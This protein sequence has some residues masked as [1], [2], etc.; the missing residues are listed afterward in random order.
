MPELSDSLPDVTLSILVPVF[1]E[2]ATLQRALDR[3]L[4]IDYGGD[5]E[6]VA[7]DDGSSDGSAEILARQCDSRLKVVTHP[8]N[9]GKGAA[10]RTG[11][12]HATGDVMSVCDAD[13]EYNPGDL[14]RLYAV[15]RSGEADVVFGTR[16]FGSHSAYSFWYVMG[17]RV[18]TLAANVLFDCYLSDLETCFKM[19]PRELFLS[20]GIASSGFGLE[21][22]V[23]AKLL[24]SG[25]RP[26]EIPIDYRA[27][28]RAEG[29][30]LT[31]RD[32]LQALWILGRV[33]VFGR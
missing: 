26:Y 20:L 4:A 10:I 18:V 22:E 7:I 32:G 12:E 30:K 33:R 17:N 24:R 13:L 16:S 21:A 1:N 3:M 15:I 29:K 11:A 19:M 2:Q 23:T 14:A 27:R 25:H 9:R 5:V 8:A 28:T 31:W 6:F